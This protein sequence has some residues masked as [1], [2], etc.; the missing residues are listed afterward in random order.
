[1]KNNPFK[2]EDKFSNKFNS[3]HLSFKDP[4]KKHFKYDPNNNSFNKSNSHK[5]SENSIKETPIELHNTHLFPDLVPIKTNTQTNIESN[6][7]KNILTNIT[8]SPESPKTHIIPCGCVEI[9]RIG[10]KYDYQYGK[11]S[12][13]QK[14][15][16]Q[17]EDINYIMNNTIEIMKNK[18]DK[19]ENNYDNIHGEGFYANKF[20]LPN[21]YNQDYE[22]ASEEQNN[23][24]EYNSDEYNS[25]EYQYYSDL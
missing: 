13:I 1:M 20:R 4:H 5:K 8:I 21:V 18:W 14:K 3:Q 22:T 25:E 11:T 9:K 15:T 2:K 6:K 17:E 12:F 19:Y 23:S 7:F 24:D 16:E 10:Q